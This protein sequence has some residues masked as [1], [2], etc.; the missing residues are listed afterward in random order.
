MGYI[1]VAGGAPGRQPCAGSDDHERLPGRR[2]RRQPCC[3]WRASTASGDARSGGGRSCGRRSGGRPDGCGHARRARD[4]HRV[5]PR[6]DRGGARPGLVVLGGPI[7]S[8][9]GIRAGRANGAALRAAVSPLHCRV[10]ASRVVGDPPLV[11]ARTRR[12]RAIARTDP[13]R[14]PPGRRDQTKGRPGEARCRGRGLDLHA[15]A[16]GRAGPPRRDALGRR[17]GAARPGRRAAARSW[18]ASRSGSSTSA[19]RPTRLTLTGD[20]DAAV[21]GASAVLLQLRVGGQQARA[22]DES[23]P[24]E[25]GC[26]GQETTGA[27]GLA[28]ALRTVPVVLDLAETVRRRAAPDAWIV[29][30]TNPVG[31]VTRALLQE[32][33][34]A[35]GLCNVAIGFQ[36]LFAGWLDVAPADVRLDHVGLNHLTWIRRVEVAGRDVLPE[37]LERHGDALAARLELPRSLLDALGVVP[38]YYLRYFYA[39]DEVVRELRASGTRAEEVQRDRGRAA[40]DVPR[41]G[42]GGEARAARAARR[43]LLLGGR[44]RAHRLAAGRGAGRRCARGQRAQRRVPA[45]PGRRRRHRGAVRCRAVRSRPASDGAARAAVRRPGRPRLGVRG[46]RAAGGAA[47]G[48]RPHRGRT[49]RA[50]A[51][52]S[53]RPRRDPRPTR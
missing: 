34:R 4:P 3:V 44:R 53:V 14:H 41:P 36:R 38:S 8:A 10:V 6:R 42:A 37:I 31:I 50:P 24:L 2:R 12:R 30:F 46:P 22:G 15:R 20:R 52:G 49:A 25:C 7:G 47:R 17:A 45:V 16:R 32:G 9:G 40:R 21:D 43:C 27:G 13:R 29:D 39:H 1:P 35:V 26:V 48:P 23:F 5:R 18:A 28:K 11:G 19:A 51:R 33:H